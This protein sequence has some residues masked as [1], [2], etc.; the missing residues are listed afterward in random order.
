ML[1]NRSM[2]QCPVIPELPYPDISAATDWLCAAFGF[3]VRLRIADHRAQLNVG[4]GAVVLTAGQAA[5]CAVMVRVDDVDA[6]CKRS[7]GFGARVVALPATYPYG[8]RQYSVQ[9]IGGHRWT[10]SQSVADVDPVDWG[11]QPG[12]TDPGQKALS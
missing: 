8:E 6:H 3:T 7:T 10:F 9:D 11:G 12:N 2:P 5:P 1:D 4:D